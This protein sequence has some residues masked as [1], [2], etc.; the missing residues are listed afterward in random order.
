M[1]GYGEKRVK[2]L[3]TS[4]LTA[5]E[6]AVATGAFVSPACFAVMKNST[7]SRMSIL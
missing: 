3:R 6:L 5:D 1:L 7:D 2:K 4:T